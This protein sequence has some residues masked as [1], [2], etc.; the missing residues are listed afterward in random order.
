MV[1]LKLRVAFRDAQE[2]VDDI[3]LVLREHNRRF[4]HRLQIDPFDQ[5]K[6]ALRIDRKSSGKCRA[7]RAELVITLLKHLAKAACRRLVSS[8]FHLICKKR[9]VV[10]NLVHVETKCPIDDTKEL[11]HESQIVFHETILPYCETTC[12]TVGTKMGGKAERDR[13]RDRKSV[14]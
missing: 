2:L 1:R 8:L 10:A 5:R 12:Q 11:V 4:V 3:P 7:G 14:A 13:L 6:A 9:R